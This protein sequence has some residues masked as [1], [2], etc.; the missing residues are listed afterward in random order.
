MGHTIVVQNKR[1]H[2]R[3][4]HASFNIQ[5][6]LTSGSPLAA[7]RREGGREGGRERGREEGREGGRDAG[8]HADRQ[9]AGM[10]AGRVGGREAGR[11]AVLY[12]L[13]F[14]S[15]SPVGHL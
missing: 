8:R 7:S 15:H 1:T 13:T 5:S 9:Q 3:T 10:Q 11:H 12:R 14:S 6:P 2:K 4:S